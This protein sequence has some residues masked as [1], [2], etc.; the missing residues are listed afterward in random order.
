MSTTKATTDPRDR[1]FDEINVGE[2]LPTLEVDVTGDHII[3]FQAFLGHLTPEFEE[4][5][6]IVGNNLH[7]DE[8]YSRRN[9]FGGVVGDAHH[10]IQ[11]LCQVVTDGLPWGSLVSGHSAIDIKL[12]NPTRPGDHVV[13]TG[14]IVDKLIEDGRQ[15]IVC[16]VE[17]IKQDSKTVAVGTVRAHVPQRPA[18]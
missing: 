6:W 16:E 4:M 10:T 17:A 12:T 11:Y 7:L 14:R 5:K 13:A 15:I 2:A 1:T 8:D 3:A 9:M 18:R